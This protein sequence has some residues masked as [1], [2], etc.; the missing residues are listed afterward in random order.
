MEFATAELEVK[1]VASEINIAVNHEGYVLFSDCAILT[2]TNALALECEMELLSRQF[3]IAKRAHQGAPEDWKMAKLLLSVMA[4]PYND[5]AAYQFLKLFAGK[6]PADSARARAAKN[7]LAITQV[8][9]LGADNGFGGQFAVFTEGERDWRMRWL[10]SPSR[11]RIHDACRAL[12]ANGPWTVADLI[13]YLNAQEE[14]TIIEGEGVYVGTLHSAKGME[15]D[16]VFIVGCEE[17]MLPSSQAIKAGPEAIEEERRLLYV[18]MTRARHDLFLTC[19][20]TRPQ[21]RGPHARLGPDQPRTP[22]RFIKEAG[23]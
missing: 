23:L 1:G 6:G 8:Y 19:S 10:S 18:G 22:S 7:G 12:S 16:L 4:N 13:A 5:I 11:T 15:W 14:T 21:W 9:S 20:Q 17:G 2:R 3:P